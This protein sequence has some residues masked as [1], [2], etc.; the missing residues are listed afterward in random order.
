MHISTLRAKCATFRPVR[1]CDVVMHRS[2]LAVVSA[3][4]VW[5]SSALSSV[6]QTAT[7]SHRGGGGEFLGLVARGRILAASA[8]DYVDVFVE[9]AGGWTT[10]S[11]AASLR[12]P[13]ALSSSAQSISGG[14]IVVRERSGTLPSYE[15]LFIRPA[16][17]WAGTVGPRA[18]L[19]ASD[20]ANLTTAAAGGRTIA[21]LGYP[22][23]STAG[24]V[25]VFE[26]PGAGWA[27]E[28]RESAVLTDSHG[29]SLGGGLAIAGDHVFATSGSRVDVFTEPATGWAGVI[30]PSATLVNPGSPLEPI[31]VS[32]RT[33]LAGLSL[34]HEPTK[35]WH[36]VVRPAAVLGVARGYPICCSVAFSGNTAAIS[37]YNLGAGH[38]CPCRARVSIFARPKS[39]WRGVIVKPPTLSTRTDT[40]PLSVALAHRALF[41]S[42]GRAVRVFRLNG[43]VP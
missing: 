16:G 2:C 35:A 8:A 30:H 41:T 42:G 29:A 7:L 19:G 4:L 31:E 24:K 22:P 3:L 13:A 18:R 25:Y 37:T 14:A 28:V 27:G 40:G 26:E 33:V 32:D 39:G 17:G 15:G 23:A 5:P 1:R 21:A 6:K 38:D 43:A 11:Q 20:G 9:R 12:D 34:F 36:G 10:E